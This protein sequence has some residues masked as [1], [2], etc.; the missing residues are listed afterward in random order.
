MVNQTPGSLICVQF[1]IILKLSVTLYDVLK[2]SFFSTFRQTKLPL[3]SKIISEI[4]RK[5]VKI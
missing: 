2:V 5:F 3:S 4:K 1:L